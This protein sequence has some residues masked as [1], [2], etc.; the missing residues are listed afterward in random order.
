[1]WACFSMPSS[2]S[3]S[4]K[5]S[6]MLNVLEFPFSKLLYEFKWVTLLFDFFCLIKYQR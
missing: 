3:T 2:C 6:K 4:L 5:L 1:M